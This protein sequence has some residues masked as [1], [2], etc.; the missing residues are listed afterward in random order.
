MPIKASRMAQPALP[1]KTLLGGWPN[2]RS[3]ND[4]L[5]MKKY[6]H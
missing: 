5:S 1:G 3:Q 4:L 6:F 2:I